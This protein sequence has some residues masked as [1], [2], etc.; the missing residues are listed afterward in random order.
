MQRGTK[1]CAADPGSTLSLGPDSAEQR[2]RTML[3]IA[4][5]TLRRVR[6]TIDNY[7]GCGTIRI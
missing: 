5:T 1:R 7:F 2:G 6:D 4:K 3:R